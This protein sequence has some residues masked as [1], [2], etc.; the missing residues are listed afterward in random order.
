M[1]QRKRTAK[2]NFSGR[3]SDLSAR[4]KARG[5]PGL[6]GSPVV[7]SLLWGSRGNGVWTVTVQGGAPE[8]FSGG[9]DGA[10][11]DEQNDGDS[12]GG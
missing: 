4:A 3:F 6:S 12:G 5:R 10:W 9:N 2:I 1:L 7:S 11:R 8:L